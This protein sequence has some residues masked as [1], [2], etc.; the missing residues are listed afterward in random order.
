[1]I[2]FNCYVGSDNNAAF[3]KNGGAYPND[4]ASLYILLYLQKI[5]TGREIF[6]IPF[7]LKI[8]LPILFMIKVKT[9]FC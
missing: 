6:S 5:S 2:Y 7:P 4:A 1:M 9:F 8:F 3:S